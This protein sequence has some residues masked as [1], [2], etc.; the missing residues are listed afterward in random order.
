MF[1]EM[2]SRNLAKQKFVQKI[3]QSICIKAFASIIVTNW[4]WMSAHMW[5][6]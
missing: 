1:D 5:Q 3:V 6:L 2:F 4:K